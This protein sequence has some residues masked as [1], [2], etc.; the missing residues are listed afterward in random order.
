[1]IEIEKEEHFK[2]P[3]APILCP[4]AVLHQAISNRWWLFGGAKY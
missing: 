4:Q 1:V 2:R 3:F